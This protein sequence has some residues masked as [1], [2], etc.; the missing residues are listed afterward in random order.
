MRIGY[1]L[2]FNEGP[3]SG[4]WK[5]VLGQVTSWTELGEEVSVYIIYRTNKEPL[6]EKLKATFPNV[7]VFSYADARSR[8][9]AWQL[10]ADAIEADRNEVIYWRFDLFYPPLVRVALRVP[11]IVELNTNDVIEFCLQKNI[12]CFYHRLTRWLSFY[13]AKGVVLVAHEIK[14]VLPSS[15]LNRLPVEVIGNGVDL[16][17][18]PWLPPTTNERPHLVFLG[19]QGQP[20]HGVDKLLTLA[21]LFPH[22]QVDVIGPEPPEGYTNFPNIYFHGFLSRVDYER[23][24]AR[25]DVAIGTLALHRKGLN[26]ASPLKVREYLAYGLPVVMAYRDTDFLGGAPFI[27]ELPN[28]EDNIQ[29]Y[30]N[31][32][33]RFVLGWMGRRVPRDAVFHLDVRVK[34]RRRLE[35]MREVVKNAGSASRA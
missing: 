9:R 22:W 33:E 16:E 1:L 35:F 8:L 27:L 25:S 30:R 6:V 23:V 2:H 15:L 31:Q 19:S 5:K 20:W 24:L 12:R 10:A 13:L 14:L 34:E 17:S 29:P 7:R 28:R 32:I 21:K 18:L 3:E 26:E 4:V 11:L